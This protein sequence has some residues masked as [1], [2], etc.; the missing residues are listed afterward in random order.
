MQNDQLKSIVN[1]NLS[2]KAD[3]REVDSISHTLL[4]KADISKVQDLVSQLRNEIVS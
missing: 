4:S 3:L 2:Q 1:L